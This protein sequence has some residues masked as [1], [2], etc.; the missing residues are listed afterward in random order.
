[1]RKQISEYYLVSEYYL[2]LVTT[3]RLLSLN[4]LF[5]T[6]IKLLCSL[7]HSNDYLYIHLCK[8]Q[9]NMGIIEYPIF[10]RAKNKVSSQKNKAEK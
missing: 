5:S 6:L 1:M 4:Y 8:F 9:E 10:N 7:Y 3:S 2:A